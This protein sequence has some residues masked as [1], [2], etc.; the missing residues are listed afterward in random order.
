MGYYA[1][2]GRPV[3]QRKHIII[4]RDLTYTVSHPECYI[5]TSVDEALE[6]AKTIESEE[7]FVSGGASI[8]T[9]L[10]DKADRLYLTLV[11]AV[12]EGDT[13]F[14]EYS[15]FTKVIGK[16]EGFSEGHSYTFLD[17]ER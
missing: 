8:F 2:S 11:H 17:L 9:Q 7:V 12:V 14:P 3:P 5:A 1:R 15:Q 6:K 4:T 16:Q 13:F 10:I